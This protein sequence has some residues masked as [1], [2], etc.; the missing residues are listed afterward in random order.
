MRET[1]VLRGR[2]RR[3]FV[4][5][6]CQGRKL[7]LLRQRDLDEHGE[8]PVPGVQIRECRICGQLSE[9]DRVHDRQVSDER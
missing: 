3:K 7:R 4:C 6:W 2:Q 9:F 1:I 5:P 8:E